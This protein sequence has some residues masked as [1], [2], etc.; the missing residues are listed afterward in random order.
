MNKTEKKK[1]SKQKIKNK[2]AEITPNMSIFTIKY[3]WIEFTF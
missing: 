2:M 3:K 1:H